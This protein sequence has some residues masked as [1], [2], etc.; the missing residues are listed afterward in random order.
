[1]NDRKQAALIEAIASHDLAKF[2]RRLKE[3]GTARYSDDQGFE[4][5]HWA[6]Q[7]GFSKGVPIL[8]NSGADPN[9]VDRNGFSP[10]HLAAGEGHAETIRALIESGADID[11]KCS[12][13]DGSTA[14]HVAAVWNRFDAVTE[15]LKCG[16]CLDVLTDCGETPLELAI[17][18][19]RREAAAA[20]QKG[21]A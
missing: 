3:I 13:N 20:L 10:L 11:M 1:M 7:E 17:F 12:G 4:A 15:L 18:N 8:V 14:L 19:N 9:V 2:E 6:A 16:A 5:I 21:K